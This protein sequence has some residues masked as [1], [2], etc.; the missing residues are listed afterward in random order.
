MTEIDPAL[1]RLVACL[2]VASFAA[3]YIIGLALGSLTPKPPR[4]Q[5]RPLSWWR[6]HYGLRGRL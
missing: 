3:G 5:L 6:R 2:C 4:V 1:L